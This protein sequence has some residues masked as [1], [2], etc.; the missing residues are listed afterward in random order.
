MFV[1]W[2]LP[3]VIAFGRG[4]RA[5]TCIS[6][7]IVTCFLSWTIVGWLLALIWSIEARSER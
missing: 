3:L 4:V 1:L 6:I 5:Q 2:F 7:T